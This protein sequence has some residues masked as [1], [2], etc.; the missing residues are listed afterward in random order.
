[1]NPSA[2]RKMIKNNV[3]VFSIH[4][5]FLLSENIISEAYELIA[6]ESS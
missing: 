3:A 2:L 4:S 5:Y 1:M 6:M